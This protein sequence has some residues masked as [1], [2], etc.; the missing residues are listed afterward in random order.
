[1]RFR[2]E[3]VIHFSVGFRFFAVPAHLAVSPPERLAGADL[4]TPELPS[5]YDAPERAL[6]G[7]EYRDERARDR[8]RR[9]LAIG[10]TTQD[11]TASGLGKAA[12]FA[13]PPQDLPALLRLADELEKRARERGGEQALVWQCECGTRYAVPVPLVRSVSIRCERC[14]RPVDLVPGRAMGEESLIDPIQGSANAARRGLAVFF[15]EAMAR[16][17][18]VWVYDP[19]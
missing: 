14:S 6:E 18:P 10:Q 11:F 9:L 5:T 3:A 16:G 2:R 15:R 7:V 12:V 1:L 13:Q 17:W 8:V 19:H 4:L